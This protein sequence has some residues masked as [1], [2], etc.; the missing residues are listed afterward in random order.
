MNEKI[1]INVKTLK[2]FTR[3]LMTI[4]QLPTSYLM[5]MSYYEQIVWFTKYLQEVVIPTINNNASAVEEV[6]RIVMDLQEYINNYFDNL[7][8][9]E[10][11]NNKIDSMVEDGTFNEII[12]HV[13]FDELNEKVETLEYKT[14]FLEN[15]SEIHF[16]YRGENGGDA[17][18]IKSKDKITLIDFGAYNYISNYILYLIDNHLTKIDYVIISHFDT[19]HTGTFEGFKQV[20][21]NPNLDFSNC[22]FILHPTPDWEEYTGDENYQARYEEIYNYLRLNGY[23]I[24]FPEE[25]EIIEL[26]DNN[27]LKFYNVDT[28]F[29]QYYMNLVGN[30]FSIV[31]ELISNSNHI[32]FTGDLMEESENLIY[33]ELD[34]IDL[35]KVPHH[36]VELSMNVNFLKRINPDVGVIMN[37]T[38]TYPNRPMFRYFVDNSKILYTSNES[39][40]LI[41]YSIGNKLKYKS[42]NGAYS[43][44]FD[45]IIPANADLNDY[46]KFGTY[47]CNSL[48]VAQSLLN[49][50]YNY[51]N[52]FILD[53]KQITI[54]IS[55]QTI[56]TLN[57]D[58][59]IW[60]R[61]YNQGNWTTWQ[62][63]RISTFN[64]IKAIL[65][66]NNL[67]HVNSNTWHR[68][69]FTTTDGSLVT[70][71]SLTID[72]QGNVVIGEGVHHVRVSAQATWLSLNVGDRIQ[73]A[74]WKNGN[75]R[76]SSDV[77]ANND[78]DTRSMDCVIEVGKNDKISLQ[79][80]NLTSTTTT[81]SWFLYDT[82]LEVEVI[83]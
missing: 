44:N 69:P 30:A 57:Q 52:Q 60:T 34:K 79:V 49:L 36:G 83:D 41:V 5:S 15:N 13:I 3:I 73:T 53:V 66:D 78:Y 27:K 26:D 50:P 14:S 70:N 55:E 4:G 8:V 61:K 16:I 19:D 28:N 68:L 48:S 35:L 2:P 59:I 39:K 6:Q 58:N 63:Y 64:Y 82:M 54:G 22:T 74:I 17:S 37:T 31:T 62:K 29:Y 11:I 42:Q 24:K 18:A 38:Y 20:I 45:N 81:I 67:Y 10:E 9:Q 1:D 7:D 47:N 56:R 72:E 46:I 21:E 33:N 80:R 76:V 75:R 12:N 25:E 65:G 32:L 23:T 40:N 77:F 71:D 51:E 43:I